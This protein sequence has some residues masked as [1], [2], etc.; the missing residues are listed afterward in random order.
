MIRAAA[1]L[2]LLASPASAHSWYEGSCCSGR[3]CAPIRVDAVEVTPDGYLVTVEP[4]DHPFITERT[5]Q[6]YRYVDAQ[7]GATT[8]D[9][10]PEARQGQDEH[11]HLCVGERTGRLLCLY[12][13]ETGA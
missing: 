10:V 8:V 6:L 9:G 4:G 1:L 2:A 7:P 3:D 11:Y 5:Q 12:V 13:P